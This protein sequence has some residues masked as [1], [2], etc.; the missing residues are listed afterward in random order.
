VILSE[1][2][3]I[4]GDITAKK[5]IVKGKVEGNLRAQEI[6]EIKDNG[7]VMGEIYTPKFSMVEGGKFNGKIEMKIEEGKVIEFETKSQR[8]S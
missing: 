1:S 7:K 4:Q 3:V 6:L 8:N 2:A 5:N